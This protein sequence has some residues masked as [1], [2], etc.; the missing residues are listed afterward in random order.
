MGCKLSPVLKTEQ[1]KFDK[2]RGKTVAVDGTNFLVRYFS[3]I[4]HIDNKVKSQGKEP[5]S[6]LIGLFYFAI[7]LMERKLKPIFVFDG[8]AIKEKRKTPSYQIQKLLYLWKKYYDSV[9]DENVY[10]RNETLKDHT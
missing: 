3:K 6:H 7:N 9:Q 1:I 4:A 5:I 8:M 2:I 10:K